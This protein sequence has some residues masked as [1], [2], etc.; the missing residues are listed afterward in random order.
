MAVQSCA[1][2]ASRRLLLRGSAATLASLA[3]GRV[4]ADAASD[5]WT[6]IRAQPGMRG[7]TLRVKR[8]EEVS[9]RLVNETSEP[10][11]LHWHGVRLP[12]AMDGVPG[13]TQEVVA[14]G[15]AFDYRFTPP[16]ARTF[17]YR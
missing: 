14:P 16:D 2:R 3:L 6:L 8:G 13:L 12:N 15:A 1:W 5:D 10:A 7:P 4:G 17:W 9:V 11:A